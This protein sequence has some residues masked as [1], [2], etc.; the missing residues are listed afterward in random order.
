[1]DHTQTDTA[2]CVSMLA[3]SLDWSNDGKNLVYAEYNEDKNILSL[4]LLDSASAWSRT[5]IGKIHSIFGYR[6]P[7]FSFDSSKLAVIKVNGFSANWNIGIVDLKDDSYED[8][9]QT[10]RRI[11]QVVWTSENT[12][13]YVIEN[14][15]SPGIWE[16]DLDAGVRTHLY[17]TDS[18]IR[19]LDFDKNNNEYVFSK[20]KISYEIWQTKRLANGALNTQE[21]ELDGWKNITPRMS[22]DQN[23]LAYVSQATG[24]E[25]VV[26]K[27]MLSN[28]EHRIFSDKNSKITDL[29]WSR[30]GRELL[31]TLV[32]DNKGQLK[33]LNVESGE[34]QSIKISAS[35]TNGRWSADGKSVYWLEDDLEPNRIY[36]FN[37]SS[38]S[39]IKIYEGLEQ[40]FEIVGNDE[41]FIRLETNEDGDSIIK[42][43]SR[44]DTELEQ[45]AIFKGSSLTGWSSSKEK[46]F[47]ILWLE[48]ENKFILFSYDIKSKVHSR[49]YGLDPKMYEAINQLDVSNDERR[50]LYSRINFVGSDLYRLRKMND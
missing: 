18:V 41:V 46:L 12:L 7:R 23:H 45:I 4:V 6:H 34:Q 8:V 26:V 35:I 27:D 22:P 19:D 39:K 32:S 47:Y 50:T 24:V 1:M 21:I 5:L 15:F 14:G 10:E 44:K 42:Q 38:K 20:Q 48:S 3:P 36:K 29:R 13:A 2:K 28:D 17:L 43:L 16:I 31:L 25:S 30:D 40:Q 33:I 37:L 9:L 11:N 49:L